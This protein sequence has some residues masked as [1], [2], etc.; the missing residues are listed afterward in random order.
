MATR[1]GTHGHPWAPISLL[2]GAHLTKLM[3]PRG[4][5]PTTSRLSWH[6]EKY[7]LYFVYFVSIQQ[8]AE[9]SSDNFHHKSIHSY[10]E[11][12]TYSKS[13]VLMSTLYVNLDLWVLMG[14]HGFS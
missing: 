13:A 9:N 11:P 14:A 10:D 12:P 8:C 1:V 2:M 3:R 5:A 6:R 4:T 7:S